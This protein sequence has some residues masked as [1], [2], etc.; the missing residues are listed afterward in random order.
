MRTTQEM[1]ER[2]ERAA[3]QSGLSLVQEVERRLEKTFRDEDVL[4]GSIGGPSADPFVRPV[5]Y[6]LE[7]MQS[8]GQDWRTDP[9]VAAAMPKAI[10][11]IAEAVFCGRLSRA[12]QE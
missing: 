12:R 11:I 9:A 6:Y 7:L 8:D 1:R 3:A 4:I 10:G 5:L 2:V